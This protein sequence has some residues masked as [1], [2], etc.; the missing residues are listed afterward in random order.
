MA[1][2][3]GAPVT[4]EEGVAIIPRQHYLCPQVPVKAPHRKL[5]RGGEFPVL[6][7]QKQV[8]PFNPVERL[9]LIQKEE[10]RRRSE[11][12]PCTKPVPPPVL[13]FHIIG[14]LNPT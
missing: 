13:Y 10:Q 6:Q 8:R 4:Y 9:V 3:R 7:Y 1:N 14:D 5:K 12:T 2:K 11:T